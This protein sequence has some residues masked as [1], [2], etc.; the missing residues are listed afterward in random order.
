MACLGAQHQRSSKRTPAHTAHTLCM[1][2]MCTCWMRCAN[3][4]CRPNAISP[5]SSALMV[6][7][8]GNRAEQFQEQRTPFGRNRAHERMYERHKCFLIHTPTYIGVVVC[9]RR[10]RASNSCTEGGMLQ[11]Y[12]HHK[13]S[14]FSGMRNEFS[15]LSLNGLGIILHH[16]VNLVLSVAAPPSLVAELCQY[17]HKFIVSAYRV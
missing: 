10:S 14:S 8:G 12:A 17:L 2:P 4:P 6:P 5:G 3:S 13:S 1:L 16:N 15:S 9:L 11:R 7:L